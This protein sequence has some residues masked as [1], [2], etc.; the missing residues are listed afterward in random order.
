[1]D[2]NLLTTFGAVYRHRSITM[3]AEE[4]ELTQ[5]AVSAALKRLEV[6][7]G[8]TLFVR[9]GRGIA[10]T[11]AAVALAD[12]IETPLAILETV[13]KKQEVTRVYC[14]ESLMHLLCDLPGLSFIETPL[15]EQQ[16]L[17]DIDS[18]K[19]HLAIDIA[20]SKSQSHIVE[21]IFD[22]PAVCVCRKD[23]PNIGTSLTTE[24]YLEQ[25]HIAL[26]I[27]RN[28]V[29]MM[30]FL[31]EKPMPIRTIKAETGSVSSMLALAATT[32]LL[33]ASTLSL[34]NHLAPMLGL[35][36]MPIPLD[37]RNVQYR[38]IYHR[39]FVNDEDHKATREKIISTIQNH[40]FQ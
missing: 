17:A 32:D 1:M 14:N 10:P 27:R 6:V 38:M 12:K 20:T 29:N 4:L 13:E 18:Q 40:Q 7:V 35:K 39:R 37:I 16:L 2:L 24:Q 26:K 36:V 23:H 5:P 25:Q 31:A 21:D 8:K 11:G 3:A 33:G 34:A 9:S 19:V 28:N 15:S 22:E 30:D